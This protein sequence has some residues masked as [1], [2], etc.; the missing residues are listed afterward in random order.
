MYLP[1]QATG[2]CFLAVSVALCCDTIIFQSSTSVCFACDTRMFVTGR[3]SQFERDNRRREEGRGGGKRREER[4][5]L[6]FCNNNDLPQILCNCDILLVYIL[7]KHK[8]PR[9]LQS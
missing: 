6:V 3:Y 2:V 8:L 1:V 9:S 4:C 7:A 5:L